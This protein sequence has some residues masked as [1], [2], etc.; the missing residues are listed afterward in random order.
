MDNISDKKKIEKV[1]TINSIPRFT[2]VFGRTIRTLYDRKYTD[3]KSLQ[4]E[5]K[6]TFGEIIMA[7][8]A[9]GKD[10]PDDIKKITYLH[11]LIHHI[12]YISGYHQIIEDKKSIDLEQFTE[13]MANA[14]Y[15]G[16]LKRAKY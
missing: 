15:E 3:L 10:I 9:E 6:L 7:S 14:I 2:E 5:A 16:V 11:E 4:G 8:S 13:L 1:V 12:L